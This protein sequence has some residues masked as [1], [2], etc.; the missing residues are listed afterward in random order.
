MD[1][2]GYPEYE[3]GPLGDDGQA[4]GD[5]IDNY[6]ISPIRQTTEEETY[7]EDEI[8]NSSPSPPERRF[9]Y[10]HSPPIQYDDHFESAD[11]Y[12]QYGNE[13][14]PFAYQPGPS[15]RTVPNYEPSHNRVAEPRPSQ[16]LPHS[17]LDRQQQLLNRQNRVMPPTFREQPFRSP[18]L[19]FAHQSPSTAQRTAPRILTG[20]ME[21]Q[22]YNTH[23][24]ARGFNPRN[25]HGIRLRPTSELP[26]MYRNLF[27]FGVFNAVQSDCFDTV[28]H[29]D[30]NMVVSAPTGSGKTVLFELATIR[31]LMNSGGQ[32]AKCIYV[33]PTKALCSEKYRDWSK[34]FEALNIK[35][36]ELTGDT[37]HFGAS[38]W[39]EARDATVIVTTGEKWDSLT[40]NWDDHKQIL[41]QI[42]LFMVDE[43]HILNESRGSTLEVVIARMRKRGN[44]VRFVTVSATV[45]NIADVAN[46]I[47]HGISN[48]P[49]IVKEFGEEF[50]PC[51][52]SRFVYGQPRK[53]GM[54]DFVFNRS[55]DYKLYGILQQH[56][57]NKPVLIFC[58]TRKAVVQT[59][60]QLKKEYEAGLNGKKAVPWNKPRRIE[61]T[62]QDN[63]LNELVAFGVGAHHAGMT[64]PDRNA[65]EKLF[66]D[67]FLRVLVSTST[68]AVGVNLPAHTVVI[69]G[70]KTFHNGNNQ[71]YSDLD[72][73]QMIGRAGR[74][75]FD[76]EG[77]AIIICEQEL[78]NK[79]KALVQGRTML[80]SS[81]HLSLT[82]HINSEIGLHTITDVN[83][84]KDWLHK[85]FLFQRIQRNPRHY[86]IGK[87]TNQ[88]WQERIDEMVTQ[89]IVKLQA[90]ELIEKLED[91][92]LSSTKYGDTMSKYYVKQSTMSLM[93]KLPEHASLREMLEMLSC[94][95]EFSDVKLRSGDKQVYNKLREHYDIRFKVKKIEKSS[96]KICL[97]IQAILGGINLNEYR[98]GENQPS[99][100]A[101]SVFRHASR[102][103]KA[104]VEIAIIK[105]SGA[106]VK[107]GL[108]LLR[109][110]HAKTWEDRPNVLRQIEHIGEKSIPVLAQ[111]GINSITA[112]RN[113]DSLRIEALLNR[114][115][116]FGL[117][118]LATVKQFPQYTLNISEVSV[119]EGGG[120][121]PVE[122]ELS[123]E[124]GLIVE[125]GVHTKKKNTKGQDMTVVLTYSSDLDFIDFRRIPT[126]SLKNAKTFTVVAELTKPSQSINVQIA[127]EQIA[128]VS[129]THTYRPKVAHNKY[130]TM[131]TRPKSSLAMDLEGMQE[132]PN[133]WNDFT[134][135]DEDDDLEVPMIDLT[136]S[137]NS[138]PAKKRAAPKPPAVEPTKKPKPT[139]RVE[140][141]LS[142]LPRK[143]PNGKFD[144]N[145][146]CKDKTKCR[147]RCCQEGLDKPPPWTKKRVESLLE[148]ASNIAQANKHD[149]ER[150]ESVQHITEEDARQKTKFKTKTDKPDS[151]LHQ[152]EKLHQST[153]V[154]DRL[155]LPEG[156]RIKVENSVVP[157]TQSQSKK[158]PRPVF[159]FD[160]AD[161]GEP[162]LPVSIEIP[163]SLDSDSDLPDASE[164]LAA[165]KLKAKSK[166]KTPP[167]TDYSD[168]EIDSLIGKLPLDELAPRSSKQPAPP[169][170]SARAR[171]RSSSSEVE[172]V[173]PPPRKR[174]KFTRQ[175][176]TPL[177]PALKKAS[178]VIQRRSSPSFRQVFFCISLVLA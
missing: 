116:P 178:T 143:L 154:N 147:H 106:Q 8:E 40:R 173:T 16:M 90:N 30:A 41:S 177:K 71:E 127:S 19:E 39:G 140:P 161:V 114:R 128:G 2:D 162:K 43:V 134:A 37:V 13:A 169:V 42:Q 156:R 132:D 110:L 76:N 117:E 89:S 32:P 73:M 101:M 59:A 142:A 124:C 133:F 151:R 38:A 167:S 79:Y 33:A 84:A 95:E 11:K 68:L 99:Q 29:D 12:G 125:S 10:Y 164:A 119:S 48:G 131:D 21:P 149:I 98:T 9:S 20:F 64:F 18:Q 123:V 109:C 94:A 86:A 175:D 17:T 104:M 15:S 35:C 122:V 6:E 146:T 138:R 92:S 120:E 25:A 155:A 105:K 5:Y 51:K 81:L 121:G 31:M 80:E 4:M 172:L 148:E 115:P 150:S 163:D 168:P 57:V 93:L 56:A 47:G 176:K 112:L 157:L 23:S 130:P 26:D 166:R 144:C 62:F 152:L 67:G 36:C 74:P 118:V 126:K 135:V 69:K 14:T 145:H 88:T 160:F 24:S 96:D 87:N 159:N 58:S 111:K 103:A 77:V 45:P 61:H 7:W 83:S 1:D 85:S 165:Q 137:P 70:V 91:G 34:K 28:M 46:W 52:L 63:K 100:E 171:S 139:P 82:E 75:Q 54:N 174:M 129:V 97:I 170:I 136:K 50:R 141:S 3:Y 55:L 158:R 60:E 102:L 107:H 65:M 108:E 153:N 66:S 44:A 27:K 113:Q 78:E 22:S 72:I 49:A 53:E